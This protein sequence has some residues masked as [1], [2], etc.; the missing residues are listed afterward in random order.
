MLED[1]FT[2]IQASMR[3]YSKCLIMAHLDGYLGI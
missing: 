1:H 2:M 3:Y